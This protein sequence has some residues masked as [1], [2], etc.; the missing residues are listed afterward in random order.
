MAA[1]TAL[2]DAILG[3]VTTGHFVGLISAVTNE[4]AGT[5]TE[6]APASYARQAITWTAITAGQF[7]NTADILFPATAGTASY[8]HVG[9]WSAV[10]GGTLKYVYT[11]GSTKTYDSVNQPKISAGALVFDANR[12]NT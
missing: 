12:I 3:L 1:T 2:R 10:T 4:L 6:I 8:T 7:S 11:I 5:V 9:I